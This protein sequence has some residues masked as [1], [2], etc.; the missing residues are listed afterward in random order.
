MQYLN[1]DEELHAVK[2]RSVK[3][4]VSVFLFYMLFFWYNSNIGLVLWEKKYKYKTKF[5]SIITINGLKITMNSRILLKT[6]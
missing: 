6:I 1:T 3:V 2:N 4:Q 5:C